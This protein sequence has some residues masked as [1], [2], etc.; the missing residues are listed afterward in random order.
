MAFSSVNSIL[1]EDDSASED[2][3]VS[4]KP[5]NKVY[6]SLTPP[7]Q[8]RLKAFLRHL[9][10][11]VKVLGSDLQPCLNLEEIPVLRINYEVSL[12]KT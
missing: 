7:I 11:E 4:T 9:C 10:Q 8:R 5:D 1:R 12:N 2:E 6:V 3:D